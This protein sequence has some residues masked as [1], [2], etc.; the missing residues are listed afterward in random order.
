MARR[1]Q[2]PG[3]VVTRLREAGV[4]LAQ[5]RSVAQVCG[6]LGVTGA[7]V[8]ALAQEGCG[9]IRVA[10]ARR[11]PAVGGA[12]DARPT[13]RWP[14]RSCGKRPKATSEPDASAEGR[15]TGAAG[16]GGPGAAGS[17]ECWA[18]PGPS[19]RYRGRAPDRR[20]RRLGAANGGA[21]QWASAGH[22]Y[23]RGHCPAAEPWGLGGP[24][25]SGRGRIWPQEG[26]PG[27]RAGNR[28]RGRLRPAGGSCV[29]PR[30]TY[31]NSRLGQPVRLAARTRK[32]AAL[33]AAGRGGAERPKVARHIPG[34][35]AAPPQPRRG[36]LIAHGSPAHP[37]A[38]NAP[39]ASPT[40]PCRPGRV[41]TRPPPHLARQPIAGEGLNG[42]PRDEPLN[43][44]V[45]STPR[46]T[47]TPGRGLTPHPQAQPPH[48]PPRVPPTHTPN[49]HAPGLA[50]VWLTPF[51]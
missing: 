45:F 23:R 38:D 47:Q 21:G 44:E 33:A 15:H 17:A 22:G 39:R 25:R 10:R 40:G 26:P 49:H 24:A 9:V 46:E 20:W 11:P 51:G 50:P 16:V 35:T 5:G 19:H 7:D 41:G 1:R 13:W 31:R 2:T 12:G 4:A 36:C 18:S 30:P 14:T 43:R 32:R 3:Q 29:R 28:R 48:S 27:C 37:R 42:K 8:L 6:A 34:P